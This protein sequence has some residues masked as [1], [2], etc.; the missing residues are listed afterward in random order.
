[1]LKKTVGF[2]LAALRGSTLRRDFSENKEAAGFSPFAMNH[3]E[4]ERHTRSVVCTSSPLRQLWLCRTA[5]L[6]ILRV[7]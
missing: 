6:S 1:M 5:F 3:L 7:C 4:G 2:V